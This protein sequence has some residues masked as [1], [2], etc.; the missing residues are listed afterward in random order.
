MSWSSLVQPTLEWAWRLLGVA[1]H[2]R[3]RTHLG[4]FPRTDGRPGKAALFI[5]VANVSL[6]Q[7]A[8]I[9]HVWIETA[10]GQVA[11]D[12]D[13]RPLPVRL[14]PKQTWETWITVGAILAAEPKGADK[15]ARV[16]L[17]DGRVVKGKPDSQIPHSGH[18][19]GAAPSA[20]G[21]SD[22]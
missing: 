8:E 20:K 2:V 6:S 18:V 14:K 10:A 19:P 5:N 1:T 3:V 21:K 9:T 22:A 4:E 17:S 15:A 12:H 16:R 11:P 7:D 13:E